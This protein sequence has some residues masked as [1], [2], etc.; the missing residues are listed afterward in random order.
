[1]A[2]RVS[3]AGPARKVGWLVVIWTM[4][5]LSLGLFAMA[6]RFVM[7]LAGLTP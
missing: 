2:I 4:S 3:L 7:W 1:M 6:F 5:V